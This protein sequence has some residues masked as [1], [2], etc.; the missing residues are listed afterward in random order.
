M[1][2]N[3]LDL[4]NFGY[5]EIGMAGDLLQLLSEGTQKLQNT[6]NDPMLS[7][8]LT[9]NFNQNSG[10]VFLSNDDCECYMINNEKI[11]LFVNCY[12]CGQE[13]FITELNLNDDN[14][15]LDC[16]NKKVN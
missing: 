8:G 11:E 14:L 10:N 2:I 5:R 13:D 15:C 6:D 3:Q 12:E 9:I 1:E 4:S 16:V 7:N